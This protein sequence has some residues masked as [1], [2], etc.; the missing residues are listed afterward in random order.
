M[1]KET[2]QGL[3]LLRQPLR[4]SR[5]RVARLLR[6]MASATERLPTSGRYLLRLESVLIALDLADATHRALASGR[7]FEPEVQRRI[8]DAL[9]KGGVFI[10][11]GANIGWHS[12]QL[13]VHRPDVALAVAIEPGSSA[14]GLLRQA[15]QANGIDHRIRPLNCACGREDRA[16]SLRHYG[17]GSMHASLHSLGSAPVVA[18]E[19]IQI[20]R[21]D[22]L[23]DELP[24]FPNAI[25]I[26]VEGGELDVLRGA[27]WLL[28]GG[29]GAYLPPTIVM[30]INYETAAMAG[31]A[32]WDLIEQ[33]R[34]FHPYRS[35]TL[36]R[37]GRVFPVTSSQDMC[38]G[39]SL[40]LVPSSPD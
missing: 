3:P 24:G 13:L 21:L 26:D 2:P 18:H 9:P 28:T 7:G 30:E 40:I 22:G 6:R 31:Y 39:D 33:A 17:P 16:G 38:H 20:R 37:D 19:T 15:A 1:M 27:E 14:F 4:R 11:V 35:E 5:G 36:R 8:R 29:R 34:A 10:D 32:P 23:L 12:L 25:K